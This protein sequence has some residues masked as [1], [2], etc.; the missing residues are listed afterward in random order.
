MPKTTE[1]FNKE[2]DKFVNR[3]WVGPSEYSCYVM[4]RDYYREYMGITMRLPEQWTRLKIYSFNDRSLLLEGGE[5]T[6]RKQWG[7]PMDYSQLQKDDILLFKL[8]DTPLGGGYSAPKDRAPNHGGIYLGD[9][10]L[11]HH[12]YEQTS[13]I[14]NMQNRGFSLYET[15]CVGAVRVLHRDI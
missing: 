15:S 10:H 1:E 3:R 11:L 14:T 6:Y 4:V 7:D 8:Y 2:Y 12:P 13:R 5:Y 9:G